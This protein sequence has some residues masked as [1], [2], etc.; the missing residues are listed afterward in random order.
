MMRSMDLIS[1]A[2]VK[3]RTTVRQRNIVQYD[4]VYPGIAACFERVSLAM[5]ESATTS[6]K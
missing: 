3:Y 1:G 5:L 6:S 4:P 2:L